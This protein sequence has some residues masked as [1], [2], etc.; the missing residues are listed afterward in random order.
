V[1]ALL[2]KYAVPIHL[3]EKMV[4][5]KATLESIIVANLDGLQRDLIMEK[6]YMKM[7][8]TKTLTGGSTVWRQQLGTI[9]QSIKGKTSIIEYLT[10]LYK[11][12]E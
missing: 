8:A 12:L 11:A 7:E 10:P 2:E 3:F 1:V 6:Y 4:S 9:Q 5:K